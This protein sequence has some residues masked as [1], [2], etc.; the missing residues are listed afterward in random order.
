MK[1]IHLAD[2]YLGQEEDEYITKVA[3]NVEEA[4][5]LIEVGYT[6]AADFD[7]VKIKIRKSRLSG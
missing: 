6:E 3:E 7:G 2:T 1:Y 5:P 4:I